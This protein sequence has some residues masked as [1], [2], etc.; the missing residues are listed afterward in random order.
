MFVKDPKLNTWKANTIT[1]RY[2]PWGGIENI[3]NNAGKDAYY[4]AIKTWK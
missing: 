3:L 4:E 2:V 1:P